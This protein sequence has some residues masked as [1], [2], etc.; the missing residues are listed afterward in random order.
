MIL[1][2]R[3]KT[4]LTMAVM[5]KD[6]ISPDKKVIGDVF[7]KAGEK[8]IIRHN[9]GYFLLMNL[10]EGKYNLTVGGTF[11]KQGDIQVDTKSIN[12]KQPLVDLFLNP[13]ATYP[14]PAGITILKGKIVDT[15][16]KPVPGA[17]I[18][19]KGMTES[20]ISEDD[21][22]FFIV[23]KAMDGDKNITIN[24]TKDKYKSARLTVLLKKGVTTRTDTIQLVK[25]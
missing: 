24:I 19:I 3:R 14:F 4:S 15:E 12:P 6:D 18:K 7:L 13:K 22:G 8:T 17:S 9:T 23:F 21:G 10:P 25:K 1:L 5:L 16:N 20:A 2:Q 11:Y